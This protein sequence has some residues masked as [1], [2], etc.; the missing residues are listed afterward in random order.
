MGSPS[1]SEYLGRHAST[2]IRQQSRRSTSTA[3]AIG[4]LRCFP[5]SDRVCLRITHEMS[6]WGARREG[7]CFGRWYPQS[8]RRG[9]HRIGAS[10]SRVSQQSPDPNISD[11]S[12]S[13]VG[14]SRT[15]LRLLQIRRN[16][17][18][19]D[20][21]LER[22]AHRLRIITTHCVESELG[23]FFH[24]CLIDRYFSH[25]HHTSFDFGPKLVYCRIIRNVN[26]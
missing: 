14:F 16:R 15:V 23:D 9:E 1:V 3:T 11:I 2:D 7:R 21:G 24:K 4:R 6:R 20:Y 13:P 25:S 17:A 12:I 22:F 5:A 19:S 10:D 18:P 26:R 8:S